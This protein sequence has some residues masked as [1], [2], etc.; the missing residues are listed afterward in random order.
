MHYLNE[1]Y[2]L[3]QIA[4]AL[5]AVHCNI[6]TLQASHEPH[7]MQCCGLPWGHAECRLRAENADGRGHT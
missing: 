3:R 4:G 6:P 1:G 5:S 7:S 2:S